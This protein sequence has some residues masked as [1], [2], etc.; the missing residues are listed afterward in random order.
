MNVASDDRGL[1]GTVRTSFSTSDF[2][3]VD[4]LRLEGSGKGLIPVPPG[5]LGHVRVLAL[6]RVPHDSH[7]LVVGVDDGSGIPHKETVAHYSRQAV[8][9]LNVRGEGGEG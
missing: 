3:V 2:A 1:V 4:G 8:E 6:S 9:R 7:A 5:I